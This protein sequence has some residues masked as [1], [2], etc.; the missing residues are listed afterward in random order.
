MSGD[1]INIELLISSKQSKYGY[2]GIHLGC[3]M[4]HFVDFLNCDIDGGECYFDATKPFALRDSSIDY[5]YSEHFIEHLRF[6]QAEHMLKETYR[7][8]KTRGR[9]RILFPDLRKLISISETNRHLAE[10]MRQRIV[11]GVFDEGGNRIIAPKA[12]PFQGQCWDDLDDIVNNFSQYYG[13]KY[14]WSAAHLVRVL[15]QIGFREVSICDYGHGVDSNIIK[16]PPVRWGFEWTS[17]VEGVK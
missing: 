14:I 1:D 5:I 16:D 15:K 12:T 17:V 13:H 8:L 6:S 10:Q 9:T 7:V 2:S 4:N 3:G 11:N